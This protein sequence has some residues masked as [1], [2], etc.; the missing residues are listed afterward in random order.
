[1]KNVKRDI[2]ILKEDVKAI[3]ACPTIKKEL[4]KK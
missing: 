4:S 2:N 3:K 1:M